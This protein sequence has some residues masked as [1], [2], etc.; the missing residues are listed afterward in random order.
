MLSLEEKA[1]VWCHVLITGLFTDCPLRNMLL[2][3]TYL[4]HTTALFLCPSRLTHGSPRWGP[5]PEQELKCT[6]KR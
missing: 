1:A 4:K 3:T 6:Y 5:G 2:V